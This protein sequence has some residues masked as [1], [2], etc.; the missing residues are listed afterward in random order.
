[1]TAQNSNLSMLKK[2]IKIR[3]LNN[4]VLSKCL[5]EQVETCRL[6]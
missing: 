6:K 5:S 4:L 2:Y 1:M 3:L